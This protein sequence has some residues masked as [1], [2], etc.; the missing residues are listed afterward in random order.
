MRRNQQSGLEMKKKAIEEQVDILKRQLSESQD[1]AR[2]HRVQA[3][4]L[5]RENDI[6]AESISRLKGELAALYESASKTAVR[7]AELQSARAAV[8]AERDKLSSENMQMIAS[9]SFWRERKA[10]IVRIIPGFVRPPIS[11]AYKR[12]AKR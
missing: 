6:L 12:F 4:A 5:R 9:L 11:W 10:R 8:S 2:A 1:A 3:A 7:D